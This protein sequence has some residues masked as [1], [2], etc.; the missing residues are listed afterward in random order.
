M[1]VHDESLPCK[2]GCVEK[3]FV[4]RDGQIRGTTVRVVNKKSKHVLLNRPLQWLMPLK[5]LVLLNSLRHLK[6]PYL[7][8]SQV[9][10]ALSVQPPGEERS[11]EGFGPVN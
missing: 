1:I 9:N 6:N 10:L 7:T 11:S 2:L 8:H 4:S 3:L 5:D